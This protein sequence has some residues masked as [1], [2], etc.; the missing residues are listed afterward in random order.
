M[1]KGPE[2][3][4]EKI[5]SLRTS[6]LKVIE[7]EIDASIARATVL[8]VS[9][10]IPLDLDSQS[11]AALVESYKKSGWVAITKYISGD[12]HDPRD[13]DTL[14]LILDVK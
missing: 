14:W 7:D 10:S 4:I 5:K 3:L 9:V 13:T 1:V 6:K 2:E 12:N 11:Q 8:P